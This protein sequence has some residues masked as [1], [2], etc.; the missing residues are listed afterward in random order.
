MN[1]PRIITG[2]YKSKRLKVPL[3]ARPI[4][5]RMKTT[6]FDL[7][8]DFIETSTFCDLYAGSGSVGFE[9]LSRGAQRVVLVEND[10]DAIEV[11]K[12][13]ALNLEL[14]KNDYEIITQAVKKFL[15]ESNE[16]FDI[17]FADPPFEKINIKDIENITHALNPKGILV[18]KL[19]NDFELYINH[20]EIIHT[21]VFGENKLVFLRHHS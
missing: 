2:K 7:L 5:D 1:S 16:K 9:A 14:K 12:Q 19:P 18:L 20:L 6:L 15:A 13:N 21:Q 3:K 17:I 10:F 11:L 8:K 4:T